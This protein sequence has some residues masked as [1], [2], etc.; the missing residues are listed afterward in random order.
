M[1]STTALKIGSV[2]CIVVTRFHVEP[3][4]ADHPAVATATVN[5]QPA[6]DSGGRPLAMHASTEDEA[7]GMMMTWLKEKYGA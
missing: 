7:R 6:T 3:F 1:A 5:G 4:S 2:S